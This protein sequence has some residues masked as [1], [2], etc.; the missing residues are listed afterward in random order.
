MEENVEP[1]IDLV[2]PERARLAGLLCYQPDN[3][4]EDELDTLY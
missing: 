1:T 3:L 2:I 4:S